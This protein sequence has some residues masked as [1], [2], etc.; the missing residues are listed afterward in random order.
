MPQ[1][2]TDGF[3]IRYPL[4]NSV[5]IGAHRS[6]EKLR[7]LPSLTVVYLFLCASAL[8]WAGAHQSVSPTGSSGKGSNFP[9]TSVVLTDRALSSNQ[10]NN[11]SS[12]PFS[13]TL[14]ELLLVYEFLILLIMFTILLLIGGGIGSIW[15]RH[16]H[17]N[18]PPKYVRMP[19]RRNL[20]ANPLPPSNPNSPPSPMTP[21]PSMAGPSPPPV[22][23]SLLPP[24]PPH[25]P[26]PELIPPAPPK[27]DP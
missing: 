10:N 13:G 23:P 8:V 6:P 12:N 21:G 15:W 25:S 17:K 20:A 11:S 1:R 5:M 22:S 19:G 2:L 24:E 7:R 4:P 14:G 3:I 27:V 9:F 26:P 16:R 18:D